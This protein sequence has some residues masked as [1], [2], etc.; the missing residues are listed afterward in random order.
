[1][2]RERTVDL[3]PA[4]AMKRFYREPKKRVGLWGTLLLSNAFWVAAVFVLVGSLWTS[5]K[6][7]T[8]L[9]EAY[10]RERAKW[11]E[12]DETMQKE[13]EERNLQIARLVALQTSQSPQDVVQ[14]A[15]KLSKVLNTAYGDRRQFLEQA[16][17]HAIRLQVQYGIPA[18]AVISQA[19]L[20]SS[21]G[22]SPLGEQHHNYFG[23]K[24]FNNWKG[25]RI[26]MPT[27]DSGVRTTAYFRKYSTLGDGF[28]GYAD[29]LRG[30]DRYDR[31]FFKP[32]GVQFVQ[33]LLRAGYCPDHDYL[34]KIQAIMARHRLEELD[35][36]IK[37]ADQAPY[38]MAWLAKLQEKGQAGTQAIP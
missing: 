36:M 17:P 31:A 10:I 2:K 30:S 33:E 8:A 23:I 20:E 24:A 9:T 25:D 37:A 19:I 13:L 5:T 6:I 4:L 12:R 16:L 26:N 32:T 34:D 22:N 38:Q 35:G 14:L 1:M 7:G 29:F 11:I 28:Q 18:S 15:G 3:M 21:Y 27:V